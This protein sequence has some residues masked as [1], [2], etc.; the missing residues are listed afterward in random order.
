MAKIIWSPRAI[1]ELEGIC[2]FIGRDSPHYA[3]VFAHKVV[4]IVEY[5]LISHGPAG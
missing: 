5:F 1:S 3:R 2:D 4:Q